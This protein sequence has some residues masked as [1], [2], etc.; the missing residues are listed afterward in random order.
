ML[1]SGV[2][3]MN[4]AVLSKD[5]RIRA[6]DNTTART[7]R[8]WPSPTGLMSQ[9]LAVPACIFKNWTQISFILFLEYVLLQWINCS[10]MWAPAFA[11]C[12][13]WLPHR[14]GDVSLHL[15][16]GQR[17]EKG[18]SFHLPSFLCSNKPTPPVSSAKAPVVSSPPGGGWHSPKLWCC[19]EEFRSHWV[20]EEEVML[21]KLGDPG[22]CS[23]VS[24]P[25]AFASLTIL[26]PISEWFL[27]HRLKPS[28]ASS[29]RVLEGDPKGV[30]QRFWNFLIVVRMSLCL[31]AIQ[32]SGN[33]FF[34]K[35]AS[36]RS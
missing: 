23:S 27:K 20:Q 15:A 32:Y 22:Q 2:A 35:G 7:L 8:A 10:S 1:P 13:A 12:S 16:Q 14:L 33:F 9:H 24:W 29:S 25:K 17:C 6:Q 5:A 21:L 36:E 26:W 11:L 34:L 19:A 28:L 3:V 4:R 30:L 31:H 18:L